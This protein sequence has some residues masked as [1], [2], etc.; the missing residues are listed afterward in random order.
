MTKVVL[1]NGEYLAILDERQEVHTKKLPEGLELGPM[2]EVQY[3][4]KTGEIIVDGQ[5]I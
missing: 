4:Q 2:G 3:D 1:V 5:A